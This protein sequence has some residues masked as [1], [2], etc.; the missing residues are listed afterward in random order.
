MKRLFPS[1]LIAICLC[2]PFACTPMDGQTSDDGCSGIAKAEVAQ[3]MKVDT[4]TL[5]LTASTPDPGHLRCDY[6]SMRKVMGAADTTARELVL[7]MFHLPS[8]ERAHAQLTR[9][10]NPD[11]LV[12]TASSKGD[13]DAVKLPEQIAAANVNREPGFAVRH[14]D[15]IVVA[16]MSGSFMA[17]R[18]AGWDTAIQTLAL[19]LAGT[20]VLGP[21]FPPAVQSG[22]ARRA[23]NADDA[24]PGDRDHGQQ[25]GR[26]LPR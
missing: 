2:A 20:R 7:D 26:P 5:R 16:Q 18:P 4:D 14:G 1:F 25:P 8:A 19:R 23:A 11:L 10:G 21:M 12:K 24:E 3:A 9:E 15:R 6:S 17:D 22:A 13:D